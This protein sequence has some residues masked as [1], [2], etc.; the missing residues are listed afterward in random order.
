MESEFKISKT[1]SVRKNILIN[2]ARNLTPIFNPLFTDKFLFN[3][4]YWF[5]SISVPMKIIFNGPKLIASH[6]RSPS[7]PNEKIFDKLV[8]SR[9]ASPTA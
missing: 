4:K 8:L 1:R 7:I 5:V 2:H 6:F 3:N 9:I